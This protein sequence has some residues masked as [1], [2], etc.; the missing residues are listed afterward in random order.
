M[1]DSALAGPRGVF[2]YAVALGV[3]LAAV[4]LLGAVVT[5]QIQPIPGFFETAATPGQD[6]WTQAHSWSGAAAVL[7]VL[8]LAIWLQMSKKQTKLGWVA[9]ALVAADAGLGLP[10]VLRAAPRGA[11]FFHAIVAQALFAVVAAIGIGVW[12]EPMPAEMVDD[13]GRPS[14]HLMAI[15][16][17]ALAFLQ[18]L[19]GAAY[20]HGLMGVLSHIGNALLL[21][22]SVLVVTMLITR[23][24]PEHPPLRKTGVALAVVTVVQVFLGFSTLVALMLTSTGTL[25]L[26]I[27]SVAHVTTGALTL[28]AT[29]VLS[30]Q[31]KR[32][33]KPATN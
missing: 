3:C 12:P 25:G 26:L 20:R 32:Y 29:L 24:Y 8:G 30:I 6:S 11:G 16:L 28:A 4:I 9:V 15:I 18:V 13:L 1:N 17:P 31:I 27:L 23:Q 19:L 14:Y 7:L 33:L 5:S 21:A 2:R 22:I 10:S